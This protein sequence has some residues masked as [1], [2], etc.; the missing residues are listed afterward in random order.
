MN[1]PTGAGPGAACLL[2]VPAW[3]IWQAASSSRTSYQA[4]AFAQGV[5][6]PASSDLALAV[7]GAALILFTRFLLDKP[8]QSLGRHVLA[9]KHLGDPDR[10]QRFAA[11][12]FKTLFYIFIRSSRVL[13]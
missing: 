9:S 10:I 2:A 4:T 5:T 3:F 13:C 7:A 6:F 8:F 12:L 1:K 11:V